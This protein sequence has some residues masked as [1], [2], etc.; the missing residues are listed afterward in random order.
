MACR[1]IT[2]S[3]WVRSR[4][5]AGAV[6]LAWI[7]AG[8][9]G[10]TITDGNPDPEPE[11]DGIMITGVLPGFDGDSA[12]SAHSRAAGT[13]PI[14]EVLLFYG[15]RTTS[16][17]VVAG[18]FEIPVEDLNPAGIVFVGPDDSFAGYVEV[19]TD[20]AS[21]PLQ[22]VDKAAV[23]INL[24]ILSFNDKKASP[25]HDPFEH[26]DSLSEASIQSLANAGSLFSSVVRNPDFDGNGV[27][28][29]LENKYINGKIMYFLGN[30]NSFD[31]L[32]TPII[33]SPITISSHKI[34][35]GLRYPDL[36][37]N[38]TITYPD[39]SSRSKYSNSGTSSR[40]FF[41]PGVSGLPAA[42]AYRFQADSI[43]YIFSIPDQTN[44]A[45]SIV[46]LRPTVELDAET[47]VI[48]SIAWEALH[49]DLTPLTSVNHIFSD[50][51]VQIDV[52]EEAKL[53]YV[54][55]DGSTVRA[56]NSGNVPASN[57]QVTLD[58]DVLWADVAV[59]YFAYNDVYGNHYVLGYQK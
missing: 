38:A 25:E 11:P 47:G 45:E 55:Q 24:G 44:A 37:E 19:G 56:Y 9:A 15:N 22:A 10:G 53:K 5:V 39:D 43:D 50:L 3:Q 23:N 58:V 13:D 34:F 14:E 48:I 16:H 18:R 46:I 49:Q 7:F 40:T 29:L 1:K 26:I 30:P 51:E 35:V 52:T 8:C 32:Y 57:E 28:D 12:R 17:P 31:S 41:F 54:I 33:D 20:M 42:G 36:P 59:V 21:L 6:A 2:N 4:F 27:I